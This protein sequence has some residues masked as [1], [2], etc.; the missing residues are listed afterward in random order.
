MK[1]NPEIADSNNTIC[2]TWCMFKFIIA[3]VCV[4]NE[5]SRWC[6]WGCLS[7]PLSG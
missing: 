2:G 4:V 7:I 6:L 3:L 5:D 1:E